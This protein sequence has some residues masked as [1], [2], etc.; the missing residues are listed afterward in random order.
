ML[1]NQEVLTRRIKLAAYC[2]PLNVYE[3]TGGKVYTFFI[4]LIFLQ[5]ILIKKRKAMRQLATS[6]YTLRATSYTQIPSAYCILAC[7]L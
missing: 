6:K 1:L 5:L 4:L 3:N 7:G 2:L